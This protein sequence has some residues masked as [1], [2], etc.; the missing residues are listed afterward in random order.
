MR[1]LPLAAL[2]AAFVMT[3]SGCAAADKAQTC[4]EAPKVL[5]DT[6]SKIGAVA[7]DPEAMRKEIS[8][9]AARLD[10]LAAKAGD[11]TLKEALDGMANTLK[12]LNVDDANAAVDA[13]QKVATD[14]ANYVKD[15]A[16]A[17]L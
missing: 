8:D 7:D 17:C 16:Q 14:G 12:N 3:I 9:G 5:S 6:I 13:A 10:D 15:V 1:S 2:T 11:T 4:V